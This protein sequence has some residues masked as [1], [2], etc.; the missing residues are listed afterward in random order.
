M[1]LIETEETNKFTFEAF[2]SHTFY[3][4]I[5]RSLVRHALTSI[6]KYPSNT[7]LKI[8]D[9]ACGTGAVTR[10]IVEELSKRE[11]QADIIG[12]DPSTEALRRAQKGMEELQAK[13]IEMNVCFIQGEA[14]DLPKIVKNADAVFFCNAIHLLPNKFDAF[15]L[16]ASILAPNAIFA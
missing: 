6:T 3:T 12:I 11:L 15:K 16:I 8:V 2:A 1:S 5:N 13:G 9:M 10:L 14:S 4:D 7:E